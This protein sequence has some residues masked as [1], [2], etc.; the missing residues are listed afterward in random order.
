MLVS[1]NKTIV[2]YKPGQPQFSS[3]IATALTNSGIPA[4]AVVAL[5][6]DFTFYPGVLRVQRDTTKSAYM[7]CF[8]YDNKEH[9][10]QMIG[11]YTTFINTL[12]NVISSAIKT[13]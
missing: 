7:E 11:K 9:I 1:G 12:A 2:G 3:L 6:P 4:K 10:L 5:P 8:F 13:P